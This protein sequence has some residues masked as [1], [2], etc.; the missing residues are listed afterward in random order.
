MK[1]TKIIINH[2][3]INKFLDFSFSQ[4]VEVSINGERI[5]GLTG[6]HI[7]RDCNGETVLSLK[8]YN[9]DIEIT[10]KEEDA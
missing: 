4:S 5:E 3:K 7:S 6:Y 2:K 8:M 10:K 9:P 1:R